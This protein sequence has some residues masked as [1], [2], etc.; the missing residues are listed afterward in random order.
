MNLLEIPQIIFDFH[1]FCMIVELSVLQLH[2]KHFE[3]GIKMNKL[4]C[5]H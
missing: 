1:N 5:I 2:L 4:Q 3:I